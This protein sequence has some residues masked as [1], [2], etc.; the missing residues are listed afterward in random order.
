MQG[1]IPYFQFEALLIFHVLQ[2]TGFPRDLISLFQS[3]ALQR[4]RVTVFQLPLVVFTNS[5]W[6]PTGSHLHECQLLD[7]VTLPGQD[8]VKKH[9]KIGRRLFH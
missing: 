8:T 5:A 3:R 4:L 2:D 6:R 1:F 9:K 7:I